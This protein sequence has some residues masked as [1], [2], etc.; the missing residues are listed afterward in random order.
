MLAITTVPWY[1]R[2]TQLPSYLYVILGLPSG[3]PP[4][5]FPTK[6]LYT[7]HP[8]PYAPHA[9]PISFFSILSPDNIVSNIAL[10]TVVE[11]LGWI[12]HSSMQCWLAQHRPC[13]LSFVFYVHCLCVIGMA[14]P[15]LLCTCS[16]V[17]LAFL[18]V[19]LC[20]VHLRKSVHWQLSCCVPC[21]VLYSIYPILCV[22]LHHII[23]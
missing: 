6:T 17:L 4:S 14:G 22:H 15:S 9:Q 20:F 19:S 23:V 1:G 7:P 5:G 18:F 13:S 21:Y 3:L 10:S 11:C 8:H 16:S 2:C 12:T